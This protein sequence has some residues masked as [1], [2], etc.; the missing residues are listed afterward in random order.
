MDRDFA[1]SLFKEFAFFDRSA[2]SDFV[3]DCIADI[4]NKKK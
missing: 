1:D 2:V 3:F 4:E